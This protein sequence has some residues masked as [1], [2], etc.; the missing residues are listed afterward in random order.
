M[1]QAT[2][3]CQRYKLHK[4]IQSSNLWLTMKCVKLGSHYSHSNRPGDGMHGL[5]EHLQA[6]KSPQQLALP[7]VLGC[8]CVPA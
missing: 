3:T 7:V 1:H 8:S 6:P 2:A 5:A 4:Q